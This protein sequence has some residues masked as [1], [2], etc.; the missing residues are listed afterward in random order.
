MTPWRNVLVCVTGLTPQVVSETFFALARQTPP[1]VVDEVHVITTLEGARRVRA[2]L[3]GPDGALARAARVLGV[4]APSPGEPH[5]HVF[6][7]PEGPLD[8]VRTPADNACAADAACALLRQLT[9]DEHS[10]VHVSIAGGRKTMGFH[11]G[12][13]A[14]IFA[15]PQDSLSHVLVSAPWEGDRDFWFPGDGNDAPA[16][17]VQ[18]AEVPFVRL[19]AGV[20]ARLLDGDA[21]FSEVV[22]AT[23]MGLG[24]LFAELD[25]EAGRLQLGGQEV[26]LSPI[27]FAFYAWLLH[28]RVQGLGQDG[29]VHSRDADCA[30]LPEF[31]ATQLRPSAALTRSIEALR[32]GAP[33]RAYLDERKT[34]INA[35][36]RR[37]LGVAAG[38]YLVSASGQRPSTRL[39][40]GLPV[41]T[42][43][44]RRRAGT[45]HMAMGAKRPAG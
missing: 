35:E 28:L 1:F 43:R 31:L 38:P 37:Q 4:A 29:F 8:D 6:E 41:S 25:L 5:I 32:G 24:P 23:Q 26:H 10:R 18:L 42:I 34:R 40:V 20:P 36:L 19:R 2:G 3:S 9:A 16:D 14:S 44:I 45:L 27:H 17:A 7:G 33:D 30:G 15:R 21:S 11:L 13:A 39:G 12:Y 22:Q